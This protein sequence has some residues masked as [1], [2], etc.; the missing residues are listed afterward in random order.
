MATDLSDRELIL[1]TRLGDRAAF[2]GLV[3]RYL[4]PA[5]AVAWEYVS[6][7]DDAEDVV[8]DAF[9]RALRNLAGFDA[10]KPFGPWLYTI[11]RNLARN[12]VSRTARWGSGGPAEDLQGSSDPLEEAERD[13]IMDRVNRGLESLPEMQRACFRLCLVE[14]FN[15]KEVGAM[16]GIGS[17]TVRTHVHRARASLQKILSVLRDERNA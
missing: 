10:E 11:V 17:P 3:N 4:R 6:A 9:Q 14:G 12:E 5:V 8:Q 15:S 16:L 7:I 1:R 13:D 2:G